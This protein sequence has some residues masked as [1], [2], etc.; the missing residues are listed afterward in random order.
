MRVVGIKTTNTPHLSSSREML[1]MG[2][3]GK[4]KIEGSWGATKNDMEL[5]SYAG[6]IRLLARRL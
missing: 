2:E 6:P 1:E 3:E 4:V 5:R